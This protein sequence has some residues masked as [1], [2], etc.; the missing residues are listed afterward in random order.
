M[1]ALLWEPAVRV[2]Q[3]SAEGSDCHTENGVFVGE[4]VAEG[5]QVGSD[6]SGREF[7]GRPAAGQQGFVG[8]N[9]GHR[10]IRWRPTGQPPNC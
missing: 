9:A 5:W 6:R 3:G 1:S 7:A 4:Q 2:G 8:L 10:K